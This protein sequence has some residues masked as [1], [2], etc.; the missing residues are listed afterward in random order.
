MCAVERIRGDIRVHAS[1][2]YV[3]QRPPRYINLNKTKQ[4]YNHPVL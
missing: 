1:E 3:L 4:K 2:A